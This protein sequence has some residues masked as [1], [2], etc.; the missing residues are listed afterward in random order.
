M[1]YRNNSYSGDPRWIE[2]RWPGRDKHGRDYK[3]GER[4]LYYPLGKIVVAGENAEQEWRD[5]RAA[6]MDEAMM[7][8]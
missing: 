7:G 8:G 3:K 6:A 2:A 4:V 1:R 5:F